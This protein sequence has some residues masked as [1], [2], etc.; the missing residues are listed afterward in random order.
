MSL[1]VRV[2]WFPVVGHS[3]CEVISARG[4]HTACAND[5]ARLLVVCFPGKTMPESAYIRLLYWRS[6]PCPP[7]VSPPRSPFLPLCTFISRSPVRFLLF[8][9]YPESLRQRREFLQRDPLIATDVPRNI[10]AS[11]HSTS[12]I[13]FL[14]VISTACI[15]INITVPY[16]WSKKV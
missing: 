9:R 3:V 5:T 10:N 1:P 4:C 16:V 2:P 6:Q 11:M 7:S 13:L 14:Y 15:C 12:Y 8:A